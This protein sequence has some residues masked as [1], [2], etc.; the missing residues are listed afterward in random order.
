VLRTSGKGSTSWPLPTVNDAKGSAY[1][2]GRGEQSQGGRRSNLQD[3]VMLASWA[4]PTTRDH[5][6]DRG[7][8][9]DAELYGTK[10]KPL[11]RQALQVS[12]V[13]SSGSLARTAATGQLN[14]E[15]SRWLMGLPTEWASCAPTE[16]PS[17][18]RSQLASSKP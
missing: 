5:K 8:Q 1:S 13:P 7:Q 12:G 15:H 16:T 2:Y 14:P 3:A 6:S 4:T 11:P 9:S 17:A 18:L 10:G